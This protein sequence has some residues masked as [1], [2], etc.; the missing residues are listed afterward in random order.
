M[1]VSRFRSVW[2]LACVLLVA[3]IAMAGW[4]RVLQAQAQEQP[5]ELEAI[6]KRGQELY[7][8]GKYAEAV[9]IAEH[10][11]QLIEARHGTDSPEH[12]LA[13]NNLAH[14][15]QATNRLAEAEPLMR[16]ALAIDEKSFGPDH[17]NVAIGLNNLAQLLQAT[18][19]LAEAEPLM[20]RALAI[21]EK[22]L[23]PDH[24]NV[25]TDLNNLARVA[26][27]HQPAGRGRAADAPRAGHRREE[28]RARPSR[29]RH[30]PQQPGAAAASTPT[31]WPRP[32][33]CIRRALAI[34]EKSFGPDHPNVATRLNNLA[35]AAR[36]PP[37]GWRRPSR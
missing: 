29:R 9:P 14:L 35:A 23:G 34:D 31:G 21:D 12:A 17:P 22:S 26:A 24:P 13:L 27:G 4:S 37:T 1:R 8:A 18:N 10:Y 30:R 11:A 32:S 2:A 19:R 20:R 5:P 6:Y 7:Q 3:S 25:A 33:R 16:R 15:L 36:R 28:L